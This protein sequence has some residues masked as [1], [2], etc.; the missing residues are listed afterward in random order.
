MRKCEIFSSFRFHFQNQV[1][2]SASDSSYA[3]PLP[4]WTCKAIKW[5]KNATKSIFITFKVRI[6]RS[7]FTIYLSIASKYITLV[8]SQIWDLKIS[9]FRFCP[10]KSFALPFGC[11]NPILGFS[12]TRTAIGVK[13]GQ[14]FRFQEMIGAMTSVF[15]QNG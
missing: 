12:P 7:Y 4:T 13:S 9:R 1:R 8:I 15:E 5:H 10:R 3:L 2:A 11:Q 14:I 6:I